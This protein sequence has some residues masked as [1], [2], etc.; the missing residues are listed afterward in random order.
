MA[1]CW[2]GSALPTSAP[3]RRVRRSATSTPERS[4]HASGKVRRN[5]PGLAALVLFILAFNARRVAGWQSIS[6][7]AALVVGGTLLIREARAHA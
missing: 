5:L 4:H 1:G 2:S 6:G 3:H 7:A